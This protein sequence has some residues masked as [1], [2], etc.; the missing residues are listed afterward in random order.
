MELSGIELRH[1]INEI[2]SRI[3]RE[4]YVS[5]ILAVTRDSF[6]FRMRHSLD[7]E[8]LLMLSVKG[9]WI[10]KFKLKQVEENDLVTVIKN[11]LERA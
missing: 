2:N 8:I 1:L 7:T 11:E 5:N 3:N 4:Y 6:L 10:S 9:I